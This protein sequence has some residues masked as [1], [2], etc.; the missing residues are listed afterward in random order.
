MRAEEFVEELDAH[1]GELLRRLA[2]EATLEPEVEGDLTVVNLLKVALKNEIEATETAARWLVTTGEIDVKL[3]LGRQVGDEAKHY[4][5]IAERLGELGFDAR[6]F[7]PL[8]KGYGPLFQY[9]DT[10][11]TTVERVAAGQ[12]TREAIAIVKNRQFI[13]FC[14]A[15]GDAAT[16]R[17]YRETIEPDERH[18]HEL[19][20]RL[21]L[22]Y[23]ATP[24]AQDAARRAARRTL[25]LAEELQAAALKTAGIHHA[26]GC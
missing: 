16:A 25:E 24:E 2:P 4:R 22:R 13:D 5:L 20:R 12:F 21:L 17:L 7:D 11:T 10:L 26:P 14:E 6:G 8:A 18:H 23:A 9:L 1:N 19:G 15:A 3:A